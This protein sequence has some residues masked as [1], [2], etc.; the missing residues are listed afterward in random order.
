MNQ[1]SIYNNIIGVYYKSQVLMILCTQYELYLFIETLARKCF[2][3]HHLHWFQ[4]KVSQ[5]LIFTS[6]SSTEMSER[7]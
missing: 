2:S 4:Y 3:W 5:A 6:H 1:V 7:S